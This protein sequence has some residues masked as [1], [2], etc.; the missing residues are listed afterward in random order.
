MYVSYIFNNYFL[1]NLE[2]KICFDSCAC[3]TCSYR[4]LSLQSHDQSLRLNHFI[5]ISW[6]FTFDVLCYHF[7]KLLIDILKHISIVVLQE[8]DCEIKTEED[9]WEH[10]YV[11]HEQDVMHDHVASI[12]CLKKVKDSV[13]LFV[14]KY[15][16]VLCL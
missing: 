16:I 7:I 1:F 15:I 13:L 12:K 6:S 3:Y 14:Y 2:F 10:T 8:V 11:K 9:E 4:I 5:H